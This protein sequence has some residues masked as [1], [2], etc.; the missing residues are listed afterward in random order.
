MWQEAAKAAP[1]A[2]EVANRVLDAIEGAAAKVGSQAQ[3]VWPEIVQARQVEGIYLAV[4]GL[5]VVVIVVVAVARLW[6]WVPAWE[7]N[8]GATEK[9]LPAFG[10]TVLSIAMAFACWG[11][12]PKRGDIAAIFAPEGQYVREL[13]RET[14]GGGR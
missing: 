6:K 10:M 11:V 5:A 7:A 8:M 13:V 3:R 2:A 12:A 9:G 1:S 14:L 4:L